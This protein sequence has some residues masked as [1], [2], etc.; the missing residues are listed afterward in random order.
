MIR[1]LRRALLAGLLAAPPALAAA[2][3]WW[4]RGTPDPPGDA[5]TWAPA[6]TG[7]LDPSGLYEHEVTAN[8]QAM[9]EKR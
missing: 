9:K 3:A 5:A 1:H 2:W 7:R 8:L 4:T 6:H